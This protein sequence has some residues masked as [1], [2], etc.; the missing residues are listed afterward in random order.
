LRDSM[1]I[2][3]SAVPCACTAKPQCSKLLTGRSA[4]R[5]REVSIGGPRLSCLALVA[6]N[7][8]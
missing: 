5:T 4:T 6:T 7:H 2:S 8:F 3:I 1:R